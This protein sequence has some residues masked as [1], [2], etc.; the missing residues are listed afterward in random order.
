MLL[1]YQQLHLGYDVPRG[2]EQP[3]H[4][5]VRVPWIAAVTTGEMPWPGSNGLLVAHGAKVA[6]PVVW[7]LMGLGC[8]LWPA[9]TTWSFQVLIIGLTKQ[10]FGFTAG[11]FCSQSV[12][13]LLFFGQGCYLWEWVAVTQ[14]SA[15]RHL[16]R[17]GC[18]SF[19]IYRGSI[20]KKVFLHKTRRHEQE[21]LSSSYSSQCSHV[22][23]N[24]N[25]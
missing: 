19:A 11:L 4:I 1:T 23:P 21:L 14:F 13:L 20:H 12:A 16:N 10:I 22:G 17:K 3:Q 6:S 5:I 7:N 25:T 15:L 2:G 9:P 24:A 18:L 8:I